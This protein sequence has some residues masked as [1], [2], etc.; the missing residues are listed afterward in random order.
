MEVQ[1]YTGMEGKRINSLQSRLKTAST[2]SDTKLTTSEF[3]T[4]LV[5]RGDP[6]ANSTSRYWGRGYVGVKGQEFTKLVKQECLISTYT[7]RIHS[8]DALHEKITSL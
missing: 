3:S 7:P 8:T 2:P 6:V 5:L 4:S 1:A